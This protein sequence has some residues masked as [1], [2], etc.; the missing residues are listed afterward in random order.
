MHEAGQDVAK[1]AATNLIQMSFKGSLKA[2]AKICRSSKARRPLLECITKSSNKLPNSEAFRIFHSLIARITRK[3][4]KIF[5]VRS[6]FK[7]PADSAEILRKESQEYRGG[8]VQE[9]PGLQ[10]SSEP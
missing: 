2:K 5:E 6:S 8:E 3:T 10:V 1:E 7:P 9:E 4:L